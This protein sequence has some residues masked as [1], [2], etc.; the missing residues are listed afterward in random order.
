MRG[1]WRVGASAVENE[2][3]T[4]WQSEFTQRFPNPQNHIKKS[5]HCQNDNN[6]Y[7]NILFTCSIFLQ[8]NQW[9]GII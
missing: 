1:Q 8:H 9:V 5:Q 6:N 4:D 2:S 7:Q 3:E